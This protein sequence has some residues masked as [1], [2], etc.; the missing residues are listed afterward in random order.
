MINHRSGK[1]IPNIFKEAVMET[2]SRKPFDNPNWT[3]PASVNKILALAIVVRRRM[4]SRL[5]AAHPII[6]N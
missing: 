2:L 1:A 4:S 5:K 6:T 3:E